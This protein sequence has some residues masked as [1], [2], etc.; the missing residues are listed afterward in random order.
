MDASPQVEDGYTRIANELLEAMLSAGF[1]SRQWTIVM[2]IV[3]KTYGFNKKVDDIG[4]GQLVLLTGMD[5]SNVSKTVRELEAMNVIHRDIGTHGHVLGVNKDFSKWK[6]V[7][8]TTTVV[9]STTVV[10]TTTR[11]GQNNHEGVVKLTTNG[12]SKQP[13]QKTNPKEKKKTTPKDMSGKSIAADVLAKFE[14]FYASYPKKQKRAEAER[15]FA[16]LNPDDALLETM[17]SAVEEAKAHNRDWKRDG[18]Q[19]IPLPGSWINGERWT[20]EAS[21]T[22]YTQA[23]RHVLDLYNDLMPDDWSRAALDPYSENR[24]AAIDE[25]LTFSPEK[26]QMPERYF[27]HCAANLHA[28]PRYGFDWLISRK[29]FIHVREGAVKLREA[30]TA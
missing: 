16:K 11:G 3:R 2:A 24:A 7:V 25:F 15:A 9:N 8:K 21:A 1:T 4:L 5:K 27:A 10:K 12:W 18:G 29:T 17:L 28:D 23:Q 13:P 14:R 22:A 30:V 19:F 6:G 20:D 26:Q